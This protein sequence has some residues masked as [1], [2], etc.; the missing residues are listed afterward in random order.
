MQVF[1]DSEEAVSEL[2]PTVVG[3]PALTSDLLCFRIPTAASC[4]VLGGLMYLKVWKETPFILVLAIGLLFWHRNKMEK[5][6]N[7][8][9]KRP[10]LLSL[11]KSK[12]VLTKPV[13]QLTSLV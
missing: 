13:I 3:T 9:K 1:Q 11:G 10:Q 5:R 7:F 8:F 12:R 4:W 2:V 6:N